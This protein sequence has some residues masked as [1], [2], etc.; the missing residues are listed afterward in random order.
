M[1]TQ[2]TVKREIE[3]ILERIEKSKSPKAKKEDF[4]TNKQEKRLLGRLEY[5]RSV[6]RYLESKPSESYVQSERERL[7]NLLKSI[8]GR[9]Q[10][11]LNNLAPKDA[12]PKGFRSMFN[13]ETGYSKVK[14]QIK[15]I[16]FILSDAA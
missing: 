6:E 2:L 15:T 12:D 9:F 3:G 7:A 16:D 13:R 10:Y 5:L 1:K 14:K 4:L 11:W 8:D